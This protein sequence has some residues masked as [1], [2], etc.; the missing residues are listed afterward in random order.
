MD[1]HIM[2]FG[3]IDSCQSAFTSEIVKA[4]LVMSLTHASGTVTS[5]L[6]FTFTFLNII[7]V[8]KL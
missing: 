6:T 3:T 5:V 4:L 1:G 2:R 8:A 7:V